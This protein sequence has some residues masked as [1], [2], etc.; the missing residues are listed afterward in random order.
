MAVQL[1]NFNTEQKRQYVVAT[2]AIGL[3]LSNTSFLLRVWM[4]LATVKRLTLED[5]FMLAGLFLSYGTAGCLIYGLST[6]LAQPFGSLTPEER[7]GFLL[8]IWIIQKFQPPTLFC[9]KASILIF[10][11]RIF[12]TRTFRR[13]SW[14]VGTFTLLWTIGSFFGTIFQ[15]SPPSFF[16][17]KSGGPKSGS[18][19][20]NTLLT[21]GL[22]S[23][24]ASCMGDIIIFLMPIPLL[25]KLKIDKK[26]RMGLIAV[27]TVGIF[28][29]FTSFIRWIALL[30]APRDG[31]NSNQVQ[32]GVW[33]Y[34]ELSIGVTCA[35]LPFL[36][37]LLGC[38]G[39]RR[40]K[41]SKYYLRNRGGIPN[42]HTASQPRDQQQPPPHDETLAKPSRPRF[43]NGDG[44]TRLYDSISLSSLDRQMDDAT[45][46]DMDNNKMRESDGTDTK[47][48]LAGS[49]DDI[50]MGSMIPQ[51]G[52]VHFGGQGGGHFR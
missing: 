3:V 41:S 18:C 34:L 9:I 51:P 1:D 52:K 15:C 13:V 10:N 44:F 47:N 42:S 46:T 35:N 26:T 23:G 37:P 43:S 19:V 17:D 32:V 40:S 28:V 30:G 48:L 39:P 4:R 45:N 16:W 2:V 33:T 27:F 36:A 11:A 22:T 12:K 14:G 20:S 6:G 7:R 49:K 50:E 21:I 25:R 24:V 8:S 38:V 5:W 31:F 29:V